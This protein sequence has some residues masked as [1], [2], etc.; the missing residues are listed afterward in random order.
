MIFSASGVSNRSVCL[1]SFSY[2][3]LVPIPFV[4]A[5]VC[6]QETKNWHLK[7]GAVVPLKT[8]QLLP[9]RTEVRV[10]FCISAAISKKIRAPWQSCA[11][12][13]RQRCLYSLIQTAFLRPN[14]NSLPVT[15]KTIR[16]LFV[17]R[18]SASILPLSGCS[19]HGDRKQSAP[20]CLAVGDPL[21]FL[22][23]RPRQY[24]AVQLCSA[25]R[26]CI[27]PFP[28]PEILPGNGASNRS[29]R[30]KERMSSKM[31]NFLT[32]KKS[33]KP[34]GCRNCVDR[35]ENHEKKFFTFPVN[36]PH[37]LIVNK[38]ISPLHLRRRSLC[39][40]TITP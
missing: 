27:A 28:Q 35:V 3:R 34:Y 19:L 24:R 15:S 32:Q 38:T 4:T 21:S 11:K 13:H 29:I 8:E 14:A 20:P 36:R 22:T 25:R 2:D 10:F 16:A 26:H 9:K 17:K 6:S 7:K 30:T 1:P 23:I 18:V 40:I 31:E 5:F 37:P 33:G 12:A 39:F